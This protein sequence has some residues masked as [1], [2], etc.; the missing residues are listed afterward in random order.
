MEWK[1]V[2]FNGLETNVEVTKCGKVKKVKVDW[3]IYKTFV[4]EVDFNKL[5][6]TPK[7]YKHIGVQIKGLKQ[8]TIL[9][10]QLVA[11]AFLEYKFNGHNLV[12]DH[13]DS[14]K[15]NNKINNLRLISQRENLSK[16]RSIKSGLPTGVSYHIRIN[17]YISYININN[18][19]KHLGY[20]NTIEEASNAYKNKLKE[21]C[22]L[23]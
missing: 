3:M 14:N 1:A 17:K 22:I 18:K 9:L 11:S 19:L 20:F 4:G 16:E 8:K 15:L 13:I 2:L 10:H 21:I 6:L 23:K 7:G 5:K 12:I